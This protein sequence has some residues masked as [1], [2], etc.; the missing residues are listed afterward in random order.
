MKNFRK[1][2]LL[3][4]DQQVLLSEQLNNRNEGGE[5]ETEINNH[6]RFSLSER[7]HDQNRSAVIVLEWK[8][9]SELRISGVWWS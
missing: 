8:D 1:R 3:I 2:Q 4:G 7:L 6:T 5:K 9:E